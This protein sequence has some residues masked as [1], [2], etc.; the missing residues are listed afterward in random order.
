MSKMS[1]PRLIDLPWEDVLIT[2]ILP[3][4]TIIDI[5]RLRSLNKDF[6]DLV[7]A[8]FHHQ[9]SLDWSN[10]TCRASADAFKIATRDVENL[11]KLVV[12][13]C[14]GW[15]TDATLVSIIKR[16]Q[17]LRHIDLSECSG[18]SCLT[19]NMI[20]GRCPDL[21]TMLLREC[22]WVSSSMVECLTM[23][24]KNLERIDLTGCWELNDDTIYMLASLQ[25]QLRWISLARIYGI[26]QVSIERL[27][28][29]CYQLE[30]LDIEGCWRVT[31]D[32]IHKLAQKCQ[33]LKTL[34][35][36]DCRNITERSLSRL[37]IQGV[38]I[39]IRGTGQRTRPNTAGNAPPNPPMVMRQFQLPLNYRL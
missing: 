20:A 31:D 34:K 38:S 27:A 29:N 4:L 6:C 21:Q 18:L 24:C 37:R 2:R 30:Y 8:Y 15:L 13:N 19:I 26:T 5:F 28:L 25:P 36:K 12:T 22:H 39:D 33:S 11:Q 35:V 14:R 23:Q 9:R 1:S 16:N 32:A 17:R 3:H 10:I 7:Q